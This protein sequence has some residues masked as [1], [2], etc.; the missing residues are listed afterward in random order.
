MR[1]IKRFIST[2]FM[3]EFIFCLVTIVY[4]PDKVAKI[5]GYRLYTVM[6]D[7]MEPTIPTFSLVLTKLIPEDVEIAPNTI[8]T[9]QANRFGDDILLTHYFRET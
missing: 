9:F 3:I 4:F 8:V 2:I 6:T 5:T 1:S 7:S